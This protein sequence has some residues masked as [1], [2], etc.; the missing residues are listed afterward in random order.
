MEANF[1]E[2]GRVVI[3]GLQFLVSAGGLWAILVGLARMKEAGE[4]R[5]REIDELAGAFRRQG[6]VLAELLRRTA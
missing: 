3:M 2:L 5:N 4:R 1:L 6:D